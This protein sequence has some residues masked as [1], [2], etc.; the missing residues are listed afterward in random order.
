[1]E[2]YSALWTDEFLDQMRQHADPLADGVVERIIAS[3]QTEQ[4]NQIFHVLRDNQSLNQ[5]ALPPILQDFFAQAAVLPPWADPELLEKGAQFFGL[6]GLEISAMLNFK[7]L[8]SAYVCPKGAQVLHATGRLEEFKGT[9]AKFQRRIME[10]AQFVFNVS[11]PGAFAPSGTGIE[12]AMKVRLMHAA[13]RYYIRRDGKWD[14]ASLGLPINQEDMAGTMLS[15]SSLTQEGLD[16]MKIPYEQALADGYFH[17]WQVA[18]YLMGLDPRLIP[19]QPADGHALGWKILHRNMGASQAGAELRRA[20]VD[21]V[22]GIIPFGFMKFLPEVFIRHYCG[23]QIADYL[24]VQRHGW[25]R[26]RVLPLLVDLLFRDLC[27]VEHIS[28]FT[29]R[30]AMRFNRRMLQHTID[31]YYHHRK[32]EFNIPPDLRGRWGIQPGAKSN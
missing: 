21:F 27:K 13:I 30:V 15:F 2:N 3:G 8:P 9:T 32:V 31:R 12:N 19:S 29:S 24:G 22:K 11:A 4:I 16:I 7:S 14:V 17:I 20:L 25:F 1:M 10:T 23:D 18:G 5:A 6:Y 28:G 26:T